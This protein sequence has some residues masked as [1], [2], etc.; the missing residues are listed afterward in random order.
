MLRGERNDSAPDATAPPGWLARVEEQ[1]ELARR[2]DRPL[3]CMLLRLESL[4]ALRE[5]YEASFV[6]HLLA[7]VEHRLRKR[8]RAA[9]LVVRSAEADFVVV[10]L[11]LAFHAATSQARRLE[12][13]LTT[14]R[15]GHLFL[16]RVRTRVAFLLP[17]M[18]GA[19]DL[20]RTVENLAA[21]PGGARE[22]RPPADPVARRILREEHP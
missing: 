9:D 21:S 13:A 7:Q 8:V 17:E 20:L 4:E 2:R 1:V 3:C 16:P 12:S 11:D 14:E 19:R 15:F 5:A 6:E 10:S 18:A 22:E